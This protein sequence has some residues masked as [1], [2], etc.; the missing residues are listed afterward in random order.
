MCTQ[1]IFFACKSF[2]VHCAQNCAKI[3]HAKVCY[4]FKSDTQKK[5]RRLHV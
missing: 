1:L 2:C 5:A 4:G 3:A